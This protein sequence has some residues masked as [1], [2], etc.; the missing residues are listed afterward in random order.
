MDYRRFDAALRALDAAVSRRRG[1]A[2]ALSLAIAA[3][4]A[5]PPARDAAVDAASRSRKEPAGRRP[6]LEGPCG[7]GSVKANACRRNDECCT[8]RCDRRAAR[9][10]P[11]GR[12]RCR[13]V[14]RGRA[15]ADDGHCCGST[16]CINGACGGRRGVVKTGA[17]C[18]ARDRCQD[19][20]ARCTTLATN[21]ALGTFCLLA[22]YDVC[23]SANQCETGTCVAGSCGGPR[24]T[25]GSPCATTDDCAD[26]MS[27]SSGVCHDIDPCPAAFCSGMWCTFAKAQDDENGGFSGSTGKLSS[28]N[29]IVMLPDKSAFISVEDTW[30]RIQKFD[31]F[32]FEWLGTMSAPSTT[33]EGT[34]PGTGDGEFNEPK[35][36]LIQPDGS[37]AYVIDNGNNRITVIDPVAWTVL[38]QIPI[39]SSAFATGY[40][41]GDFKAAALDPVG[42][43]ILM[44]LATYSFPNY[45]SSLSIIP[46]DGGTQSSTELSVQNLR[47]IAV[48][49]DG[50]R[51]YLAGEKFTTILDDT[52]Q[53]IPNS[54]YGSPGTSDCQDGFGRI[55]SDQG[56]FTIDDDGDIWVEDAVCQRV[57][58]FDVTGDTWTP[59]TWI[60]HLDDFSG[61][62]PMLRSDGTLLLHNVDSENNLMTI[63]CRNPL[64]PDGTRWRTAQQSRRS[65]RAGLDRPRSR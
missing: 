26:G 33:G 7:D 54:T 56:S 59:K 27:C 44:L 19:P 14:R 29:R 64:M 23:T 49:A 15:C 50:S 61:V 35:D 2:G 37:E 21:P 63:R 55:Q 48:K 53:E 18:G 20:K 12:G 39:T 1:L 16:R 43:R 8:G 28:P 45:I 22:K 36:I 38:R 31:A 4:V 58:Q 47:N 3:A 32:T 60:G 51:I 11:E 10:D 6:D 5:A 42:N 46:I 30:D 65:H 34:E 25:A 62:S 52:F 13:C 17:A 9:L 41:L 57:L 40:S 24:P